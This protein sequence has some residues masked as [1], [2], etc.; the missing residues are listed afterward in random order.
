MRKNIL[1]II[2]ASL[3][4]NILLKCSQY[5]ESLSNPPYQATGIKICEVDTESAVIWARLTQHEIRF[6]S[7]TGQRYE[8]FRAFFSSS[9]S[10]NRSIFPEGRRGRS[11]LTSNSFGT[12]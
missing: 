11:G 12:L 5:K 6:G 7:G 10:V 8:P 1:I 3:S 2:I 4:L 9:M